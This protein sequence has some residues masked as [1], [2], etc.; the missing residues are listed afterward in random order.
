MPAAAPGHR[1]HRE[2][3]RD[4]GART[5]RRGSHNELLQVRVSRRICAFCAF[6]AAIVMADGAIPGFYLLPFRPCP[7]P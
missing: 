2:P 3:R 7:T 6:A 4:W 5:R 1:E